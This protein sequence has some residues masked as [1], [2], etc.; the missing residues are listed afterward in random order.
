M[1]IQQ[2]SPRVNKLHH[3][4]PP[5]LVQ[6][7]QYR[8]RPNLCIVLKELVF[9]IL[10]TLLMHHWSF[11]NPKII[12]PNELSYFCLQCMRHFKVWIECIRVES[13]TDALPA[14]LELCVVRTQQ[15]VEATYVALPLLEWTKNVIVSIDWIKVW[16]S[17]IFALID[18]NI[19][20]AAFKIALAWLLSGKR[21]SDFA[22]WCVSRC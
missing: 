12:F 20:N 13:T 1:Y 2:V 21:C 14:L 15:T 4:S 18:G 3:A 17:K 7:H 11:H 10:G 19:L 8:K 22:E 5:F 9:W 6:I 16:C